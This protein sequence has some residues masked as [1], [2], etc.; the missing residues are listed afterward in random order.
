MGTI[1]LEFIM[2]MFI[3]ALGAFVWFLINKADNK[4]NILDKKVSSLQ[5]DVNEKHNLVK[6]NYILKSSLND[7]MTRIENKISETSDILRREMETYNKHISDK[8]DLKF[9]MLHKLETLLKK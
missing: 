7:T 6:E 9:E 1:S 3:G 8:M 2:K 4:I 5:K